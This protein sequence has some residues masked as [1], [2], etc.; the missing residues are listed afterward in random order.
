MNGRNIFLK[1]GLYYVLCG[2]LV[3]IAG[4]AVFLIV[5]NLVGHTVY[6]P[7]SSSHWLFIYKSSDADRVIALFL[8]QPMLFTGLAMSYLC[9]RIARFFGY[10][11]IAFAILG[12][13]LNALVVFLLLLNICLSASVWLSEFCFVA[14]I[15]WGFVSGFLFTP[16]FLRKGLRHEQENNKLV[17]G[18]MKPG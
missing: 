4:Q 2:S 18:Q 17:Q 11:Q 16:V 14:S 9:L 8:Y 15:F 6:E 7:R 5:S 13:V 12:G 10:H 1:N 3:I